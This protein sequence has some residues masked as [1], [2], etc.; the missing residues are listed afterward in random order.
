[1]N[2]LVLSPS[3][4]SIA[5]T[6][7]FTLTASVVMGTATASTTISVKIGGCKVMSIAPATSDEIS[8]GSGVKAVQKY[9]IG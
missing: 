7:I 8:P 4:G 9:T 3:S 1:M 2:G 6:Y 5:G